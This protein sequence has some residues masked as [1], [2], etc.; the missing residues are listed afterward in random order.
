[1]V[2]IEYGRYGFAINQLIPIAKTFTLYRPFQNDRRNT[3]VVVVV[4]V[5][6][7]A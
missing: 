4:V 2:V 1:M 6:V 7:G 5:V 3:T